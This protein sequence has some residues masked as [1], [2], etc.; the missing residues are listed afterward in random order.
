MVAGHGSAAP[1]GP[2][3]LRKTRD[4][5]A[6]N[7]LCF[8]A[9]TALRLTGGNHNETLVAATLDRRLLRRG[10]HTVTDGCSGVCRDLVRGLGEARASADEDHARRARAGRRLQTTRRTATGA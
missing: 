2:W 6:P 3:A 7:H 9:A 8:F 4:S 10:R 5:G 1:A